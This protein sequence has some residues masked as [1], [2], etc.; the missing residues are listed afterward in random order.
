MKISAELVVGPAGPGSRERSVP[1][2]YTLARLGLVALC[3]T[4]CDAALTPTLEAERPAAATGT[5]VTGDLDFFCEW[6]THEEAF[7]IAAEDYAKG[8]RRMGDAWTM[9]NSKGPPE[10]TPQD[11]GMCWEGALLYVG[12]F[13]DRAQLAQLAQLSVRDRLLEEE[14]SNPEQ[15]EG[16]SDLGNQRLVAL[17]AVYLAMAAQIRRQLIFDGSLDLAALSAQARIQQCAL[18]D[19]GCIDDTAMHTYHRQLLQR[20]A[21]RGLTVSGTSSS[22]SVFKEVKSTLAASTPLIPYAISFAEEL[23]RMVDE[24]TDFFRLHVPAP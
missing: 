2:L 9:I 4:S 17:R 8:N 1:A 13:G 18:D 16:T 3:V 20:Y 22:Q 7:Q 24:K 21:I 6:N 15:L 14:T 5:E 11:Q 19:L 23:G 12:V 10:R